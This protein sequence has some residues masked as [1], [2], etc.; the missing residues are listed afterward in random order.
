MHRTIRR[1][2]TLIEI[3]VVISIIAILI[4]IL[5]PAL[6]KSRTSAQDVQ[7]TS[8]M[9]NLM[10]AQLAYVIDSDGLFPH[11]QEWIWGRN[12][13]P[14]GTPFRRYTADY[15]TQDAPREGTLNSYVSDF[16]AHF[17]P[18]AP[19]MPVND[20]KYGDAP[21]GSK[22]VRSYVQAGTVYPDGG[23]SIETTTKPAELLV[24]TEENT[25][26]M[27]FR[28]M[29][30]F[31]QHF[32]PHPMNDGQ[33][34]VVWDSIGSM[35]RRNDA[36]NLRS[37]YAVGAFMDGATDWVFSQAMTNISNINATAGFIND[38]VDNPEEQDPRFIDDSDDYSYTY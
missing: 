28:G 11:Y 12:N 34:N 15:T 10:K 24:L 26:S 7:C 4:A 21:L 3:L 38:D 37:G 19:E 1:A 30:G 31:K 18:I 32:G 20:L 17:C 27:N 25:F 5:L 36:D 35:H 33:L 29:S 16:N 6:T 13:L 23:Y 14:D 9:G 2:F 22:V 8:N